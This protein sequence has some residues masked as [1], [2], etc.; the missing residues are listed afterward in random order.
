M[1]GEG[2]DAAMP[3]AFDRDIAIGGVVKEEDEIT[4]AAVT[5]DAEEDTAP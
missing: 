2:R 3:A 5:D 1:T 4:S